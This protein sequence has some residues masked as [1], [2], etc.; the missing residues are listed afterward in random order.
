[1][2]KIITIIVD[3]ISAIFCILFL[4]FCSIAYSNSEFNKDVTN[5]YNQNWKSA[6]IMQIFKT[7]KPTCPSG[8]VPLISTTFPGNKRGCDCTKSQKK[9][10][11]RKVFKNT[12]DESQI[13][14]SCSIIP[15]RNN[16][17]LTHWRQGT[18][19]SKRMNNF[20]YE[21]I[22]SKPFIGVCPKGTKSCGIIDTENNLLCLK[23]SEECPLNYLEI[24]YK[25]SKPYYTDS[26][27]EFD[28]GNGYT[29]YA[30]NKMTTGNVL[31]N[32]VVGNNDE[33]CA[34]PTEGQIGQ[35]NYLLNKLKGESTCKTKMGS[36]LTDWRYSAIDNMNV[37]D[38]YED[39]NIGVIINKLPNYP[40]IDKNNQIGL[41][42]INY[43]GV[44]GTCLNNKLNQK[45]LFEP[46]LSKVV[47][48]GYALFVLAVVHLIFVYV[49]VVA[50][51]ALSRYRISDNVII[52]ID[53]IQMLFLI[54]IFSIAICGHK[55][56]NKSKAHYRRFVKGDCGDRITTAILNEGYKNIIK[57]KK[58]LIAVFG[59][60]GFEIGV[61]VIYYVWFYLVRKN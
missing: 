17:N 55:A 60:A 41:H 61:K 49:A 19:C 48:L 25:D 7:S 44:K 24:L 53:V 18:L 2:E 57:A 6:P 33:Q 4:V 43:F 36:F 42:S 31:V 54:S 22:L 58:Y 28:L 14:N 29:L 27:N 16:T 46:N 9:S 1:M 47:N 34:N 13:V 56:V 32:V 35:N 8:Y 50:F 23:E 26:M 5:V 38:F 45:K 15:E 59:T 10:Y 40:I 37:Y 30:S 20:N 51:K 39:N 52:G 21:N 12:C 3:A 11:K